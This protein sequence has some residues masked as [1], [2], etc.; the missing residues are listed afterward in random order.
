LS[1]GFAPREF[2]TT[3]KKNLV[4]RASYYQLIVGHLY[5]LGADK[6]LRRCVMEHERPIILAEVHEGIAG[7]HY[8]GKATMC[9]RYCVQDYGGQQC[10]KTQKN[11]VRSVM[12]VNELGSHIGG[13]R[14]Y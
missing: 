8:A 13:M 10:T 7:G 14:F 1:T 9:R 4:V 5:K 11:T 12:F 6:I 2:T 3:Q